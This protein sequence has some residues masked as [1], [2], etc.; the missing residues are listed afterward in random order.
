MK[1]TDIFKVLGNDYRYQI[2]LWLKNPATHFGADALHCGE[3]GFD[4]G[5][6]VGVIADKAGL[7]QS[8]VSSYLSSLQQAGLIESKRFGKWTYYRY[9]A[10]GVQAFLEQVGGEIGVVC[11]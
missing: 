1:T 3:T 5:I 8:V 10:K 6:C 4:G 7:A 2:L 11:D 9:D